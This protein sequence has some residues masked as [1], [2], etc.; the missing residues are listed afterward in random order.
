VYAL[1]IAVAIGGHASGGFMAVNSVDLIAL[2]SHLHQTGRQDW[3]R[4]RPFL[5][6]NETAG[7]WATVR[8]LVEQG[9][10]AID[11]VVAQRGLGHDR[12]G[13]STHGPA[14]DGQ[15]HLYSSKPP[16]VGHV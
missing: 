9:T 13:C 8:S 7:R 11:D 14:T 12:H 4:Q 5:S 6:A 10:Y 1:L 2:E 16:P 3:Q 15:P